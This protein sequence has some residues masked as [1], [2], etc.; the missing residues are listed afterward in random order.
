MLTMLTIPKA[1]QG[2]IDVIQKNAIRSWAR[3]GP[4]CE[5][6]LFGKDEGTAEMSREVG[7]KHIPDVECNEYGTPLLS[8]VF[9]TADKVAV[10]DLLCFINTDIILMSDFL[11]ALQQVHLKRFLMV[12][13][14]WDH[15]LT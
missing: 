14:S 8:S 1:F 10:N 15:E 6:I 9:R 13:L 4:E 3:L 5:I 11:P 2:N 7:V 12:G